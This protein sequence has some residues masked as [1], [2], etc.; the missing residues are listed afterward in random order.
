M[1]TQKAETQKVNTQEETINFVQLTA[2]TNYEI[3]TT[4][5]FIVRRKK[6]KKL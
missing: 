3:S 6:V 1:D 4:E 2:H 5:P